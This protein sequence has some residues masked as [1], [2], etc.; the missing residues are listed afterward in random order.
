[1][2]AVLYRVLTTKNVRTRADK[3]LSPKLPR[4]RQSVAKLPRR[5][6][7]PKGLRRQAEELFRDLF[8]PSPRGTTW[9]ALAER[10]PE[11][12]RDYLDQAQEDED[13][14]F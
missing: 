9:S 3:F 14:E 11:R 2:A 4:V 10:Y 6:K 1:M 5:M 12:F 13:E 7:I 8:G